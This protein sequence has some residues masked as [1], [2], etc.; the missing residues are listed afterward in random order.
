MGDLTFHSPGLKALFCSAVV[1]LKLRDFLAVILFRIKHII[2]QLYEKL[3]Y[4]NDQLK[5]SN[6]LLHVQHL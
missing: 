3:K 2:L 6:L 1:L 5:A 4:F